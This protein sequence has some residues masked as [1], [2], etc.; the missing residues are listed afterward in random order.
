[1]LPPLF[2]KEKAPKKKEKILEVEVLDEDA[3]KNEDD[4]VTELAN[5]A[6]SYPAVKKVIIYSVVC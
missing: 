5:G 2:A 3:R 4:R 6:E 1:M